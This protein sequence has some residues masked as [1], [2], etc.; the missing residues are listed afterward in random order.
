MTTHSVH[1]HW[2]RPAGRPTEPAS[3]RPTAGDVTAHPASAIRIKVDLLEARHGG[4]G[5]AVSWPFQC[6]PVEW[7][8]CRRGS[9]ALLPAPRLLGLFCRGPQDRRGRQDRQDL[10]DKTTESLTMARPP[11]AGGSSSG[12]DGVTP[13][14]GLRGTDLVE[15]R[16]RRQ[17]RPQRRRPL[18]RRDDVTASHARRDEAW[19]G[20]APGGHATRG[21]GRVRCAAALATGRRGRD[22]DPTRTRRARGDDPKCTE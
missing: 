19:R 8:H 3:P 18:P 13:R 15:S 1:F 22:D 5:G 9:A 21:G 16:R 4:H 12:T 6:L 20:V 14:D 10:A 11:L 17:G 2:E 7:A